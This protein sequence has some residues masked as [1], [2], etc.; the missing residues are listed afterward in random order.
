MLL[1]VEI[2]DF[3]DAVDRFVGRRVAAIAK[4]SDGV[5]VTA[6]APDKHTVVAATSS[7]PLA[8]VESI[9]KSA[10]FEV[11]RG[12]WRD[13]N[14]FEAGIDCNSDAFVAAVAYRSREEMPGLWMDA[15]PHEPTTGEVLKALYDD[16][17]ATGDLDEVPFE[18]FIRVAHPNVVVL[19]PDD[20]AKF[21]RLHA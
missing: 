17:A 18:E 15:F 14:S 20:V 13:G 8:D 10:G 4:R 19:S 5:V 2:D 9:L 7:K 12:E 21:L 6:A 1:R 11:V 16:F 3:A